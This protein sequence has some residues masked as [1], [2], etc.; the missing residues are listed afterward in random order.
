MKFLFII[1][2]ANCW[3][4]SI[5]QCTKDEIKKLQR[6]ALL[7][8]EN[9][10]SVDPL[11]NPVSDATAM[12]RA[13]HRLHFNT[14]MIPNCR[15]DKLDQA[16]DKWV[17]QLENYDVAIFYF[18]GHAAQIDGDNYLFPVNAVYSNN[19]DT[20]ASETY[21][22]SKLLRKMRSKNQKYNIVI[23]DACRYDPT[24]NFASSLF[25][26]GLKDMKIKTPGTMVWF[27]TAS[28]ETVSDG[29]D[30]FTRAILNNIELPNLSITKIFQRVHDEVYNNSY[31]D[32]KQEPFLNTSI[33][34][35]NDFCLKYKDV[36]GKDNSDDDSTEPEVLQN[37]ERMRETQSDSSDSRDRLTDS[38]FTIAHKTIDAAIN[39]VLD[40][41]SKEKSK[42]ALTQAYFDVNNLNQSFNNS[43][44]IFSQYYRLEFRPEFNGKLTYNEFTLTMI[45]RRDNPK[46]LKLES[47][48]GLPALKKF[49]YPISDIRWQTIREGIRNWFLLRWEMLKN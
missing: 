24:R 29:S 47:D 30:L 34:A 16:I 40:S 28:G 36:S 8:G 23:L 20:I 7:I 22:V 32:P 14:T 42:Y 39:D 49:E 21:L 3:V 6:T 35:Q 45:G 12:E 37:V 43:N 44:G 2:F 13:L 4:Y 1:F 31:D 26:K 25:K 9:T 48:K 15:Y 27:P 33:G 11:K 10:Y 17:S 19:K 46:L 5:A 18:A 41:L 38:I